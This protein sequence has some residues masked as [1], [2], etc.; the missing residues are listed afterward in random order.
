MCRCHRYLANSF[1]GNDFFKKIRLRER[2]VKRIITKRVTNM[3]EDISLI[4]YFYSIHDFFCR[5]LPLGA[6]HTWEK[7]NPVL[8][9]SK[10]TFAMDENC[11]Y[12]WSRSLVK[13]CQNLNEEKCVC[14]ESAMWILPC[15]LS[16]AKV[17]HL[18]LLE[19]KVS[20]WYN[21]DLFSI[22]FMLKMSFRNRWWQCKNDFRNDMDNHFTFRYSRHY[23]W[24]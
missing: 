1:T 6:I 20:S 11:C 24:R 7:F 15:I 19:P 4:F 16:R 23:G 5:H 9:Q 14:I 17:F 12:Y 2:L 3:F 22:I 21:L 10:P 8:I 13:N 18:F